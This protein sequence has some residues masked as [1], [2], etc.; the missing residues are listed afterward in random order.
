M[1]MAVIQ[2]NSVRDSAANIAVAKNL[3]TRAVTEDGAD[4]LLLPEHFHWAGGTIKDRHEAAE[5]L[6][7]GPAYQ[8]CAQFA[9]DHQV[10]VHA[11]SIFER[12]ADEPRIYNTTVAFGRDGEEL[13]RYRKI[14]LFDIVGPDGTS[15]RESDTVAPGSEAITYDADGVTVG[16]TICYDLRFPALFQRLVAKGA[17]VIA[18]P[19][20]FTLQTGKDHWEPLIRARAIETQTYLAA[21]GSCGV[22]E[23]EGKPHWTYG[24]SMIVDP[25]GHVV[26]MTS[27]GNG[28]ATHRFEAER[29][30]RVRRDIPVSDY[31]PRIGGAA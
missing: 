3:M 29:I 14:H 6:G 12:S 23:Y 25:W 30:A 4:W 10:F 16:C 21:S 22:V 11:G 7:D 15:Y 13:A 1:K 28:S 31:L 24:H 18:L 5:V 9:Q 19:A 17:Q 8:M 27:D 20:A 2:M 26:A